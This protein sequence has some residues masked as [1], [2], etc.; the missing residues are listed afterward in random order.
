MIR[1]TTRAT[2]APLSASLLLLAACASVRPQAGGHSTTTLGGATAPT[3]V[4]TAAP[5]N[6]QTPTTT[7][8][9]KTVI[10]ETIPGGLATPATSATLVQPGTPNPEHGTLP[11]AVVASVAPSREILRETVTERAT[12][13]TGTAQVDN[14]RELTARLANLRGVLWVGLALLIGGPVV[15][16]R[17]GWFTNGCIAGAV[18][19]LLVILSAVLPGHEA[20]FGLG[21][22]LLIP[23]VAYVYYR[24]HHDATAPQPPAAPPAPAAP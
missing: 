6:P 12:T 1:H 13:V 24:A 16:W 22:L 3:T 14:S 7:T 18:G 19:L 9:E 8:V 2:A 15:G 4:T 11:S 17:L 10:R 21:G 20:W 23:L 5:Q